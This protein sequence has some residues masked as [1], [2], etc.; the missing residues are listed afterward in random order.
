MIRLSQPRRALV[1]A[2][3]GVIVALLCYF[4]WRGYLNTELLLN[5]AN[6]FYC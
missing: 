1:W 3:L 6:M 4:A 5:F 2:I